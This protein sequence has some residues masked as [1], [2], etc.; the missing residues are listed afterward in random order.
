MS[1]LIKE[2]NK[3]IY[4]LSLTLYGPVYLAYNPYFSACFFSQNSIFSL[5][6]NQLTVFF[7]RLISTAERRGGAPHAAALATVE[8]I[9]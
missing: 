3:K 7:S 6:T 9:H 2:N 1:F 5:T 4:N 8:W